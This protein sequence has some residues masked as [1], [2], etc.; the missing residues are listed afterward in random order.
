MLESTPNRCDR[1]FFRTWFSCR[2]YFAMIGNDVISEKLLLRC[3]LSP[4]DIVVMT[5]AVRDLHAAYPGRYLTDVRT[6]C[7]AI[8]ENNPHLTPLDDSDPKVR[9]IDMEC[10]LIHQSNSRP[11]HFLHGFIHHLEKLLSVSI[12]VTQFHGDIYLSE[13]E[14]SWMSQVEET[15]FK[16]RYW[17]V[18][19]GGKHDF[20]AK[21]W[22][23]ASYQL[24]INH[25][26]NRIQFVQ[27]GELQHWHPPLD[28]VVNLVGKTD[29]R[30]FIRLVYHADGVL[31]PVTLA[32]HLAAAVETKP[33][34]PKNRACVVVAGGREPP[35]WEAYPHHQFISTNGALW[36]CDNGGCWKSRCQTVG[37]GDEKDR[38]TCPQ[39]VQISTM[40]RIPRC[41]DMIAP[42]DVIRRIEMYYEG[43]S[44]QY[45]S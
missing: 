38:D 21:W 41:M 36:C 30:Q 29:L 33:N 3:F 14:K 15:G 32:M 7:G 31:C 26:R 2:M 40:L 45:N 10:N 20:T 19:A 9:K 8:W 43:R 39:P 5:A 1:F 11:Y 35:H 13:R 37:D 42:A 12:P 23:P 28:G 17:I 16:G 22:N 24:V 25:F 4:G 18:M 44:L 27:C 6:S 34:R